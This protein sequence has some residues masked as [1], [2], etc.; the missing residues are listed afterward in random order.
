MSLDE[1]EYDGSDRRCLEC[2]VIFK[3]SQC[4]Q[5][6]WT[7]AEKPGSPSVEAWY[8][9]LHALLQKENGSHW[10]SPQSDQRHGNSLAL[11]Y[12]GRNEGWDGRFQLQLNSKYLEECISPVFVCIFLLLI[13]KLIAETQKIFLYVSTTEKIFKEPTF[14]STENKKRLNDLLKI[15][16]QPR[17]NDI[18]SLQ[19]PGPAS[20]PLYP[21]YQEVLSTL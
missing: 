10:K 1:S 11:N 13:T 15:H 5:R 2:F 20:L 8:S 19:T 9:T 7:R 17:V 4:V 14:C 16:T 18:M 12:R 6:K 21:L 3:G